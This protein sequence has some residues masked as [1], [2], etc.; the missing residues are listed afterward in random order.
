MEIKNLNTT[1]VITAT[2]GNY[3]TQ[4]L[5]VDTEKRVI[6]TEVALGKNDTVDNWKEITKEEGEAVLTMQLD[7][8]NTVKE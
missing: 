3:L 6:A 7:L 1:T 2:D 8:Y 4:N 5:E